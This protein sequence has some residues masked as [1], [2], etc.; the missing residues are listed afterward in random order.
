MAILRIACYR[1]L[2][3]RR[4]RNE[5]DTL[6]LSPLPPQHRLRTR[7][8]SIPFRAP[9]AYVS[10]PSST[11]GIINKRGSHFIHT[12]DGECQ[13]EHLLQDQPHAA[14]RVLASLSSEISL[15]SCLTPN[16]DQSPNLFAVRQHQ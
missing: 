9:L 12:V 13:G 15:S 7:L 6:P 4:I 5:P 1:G 16:L 10:N 11:T 3:V 8:Q 14:K 2:G